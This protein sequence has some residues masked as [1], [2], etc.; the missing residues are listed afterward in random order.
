MVA[1]IL[2][3]VF[4]SMDAKYPD[5]VIAGSMIL[6]A[7]QHRSKILDKKFPYE[8]GAIIEEYVFIENGVIMVN[9]TKKIMVIVVFYDKDKSVSEYDKEGYFCYGMPYEPIA[10]LCP[11]KVNTLPL[12]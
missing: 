7:K 9:K 8:R 2:A 6:V 5:E 1:A 4:I 10:K 3:I 12:Y 11:A